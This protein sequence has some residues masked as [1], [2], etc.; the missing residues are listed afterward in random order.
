MQTVTLV[1]S[2]SGIDYLS[3]LSIPTSVFLTFVTLLSIH[4]SGTGAVPSH[5]ITGGF[6]RTR[7]RHGA[8]YA[9]EPFRAFFTKLRSKYEYYKC[10][11]PPLIPPQELQSVN[12][13]SLMFL[14]FLSKVLF[15]RLPVLYLE[16]GSPS[17]LSRSF[18]CWYTANLTLRRV[19]KVTKRE[20]PFLAY[21]AYQFKTFL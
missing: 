15:L 18:P 12:I 2:Y 20:A 16:I 1:N 17:P 9:I 13:I 14:Y 10:I 6:F 7:T 3:R 11:K 8:I 5:V 21:H 4:A 19:G